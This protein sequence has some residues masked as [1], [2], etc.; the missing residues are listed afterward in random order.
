MYCLVH[1]IAKLHATD[2]RG[3]YEPTRTAINSRL[4]RWIA[5][6]RSAMQ[7]TLLRMLKATSWNRAA[8]LQDGVFLQPR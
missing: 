2:L 3:S 5:V 7:G 8:S 4:R 6:M 1:N